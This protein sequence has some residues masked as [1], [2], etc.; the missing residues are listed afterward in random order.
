MVQL[1]CRGRPVVAPNSLPVS[2]S[3]SNISPLQF[4]D[5]DQV[6]PGQLAIAIGSP[7]KDFNSVSVGVISGIGSKLRLLHLRLMLVGSIFDYA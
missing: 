6:R 3:L 5:S 4:A 1:H 7:F 2:C